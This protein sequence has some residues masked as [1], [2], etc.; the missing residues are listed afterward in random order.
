MP[1]P[2]ES[3]AE[4]L[5]TAPFGGLSGARRNPVRPPYPRL[6]LTGSGAPH[7]RRAPDPSRED[8]K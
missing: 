6:R 4:T 7:T 1:L 2:P 3:D 8:E 5:P